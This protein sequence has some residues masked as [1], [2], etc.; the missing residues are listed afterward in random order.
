M[1]TQSSPLPTGIKPPAFS[2]Q[3]SLRTLVLFCH[4][5]YPELSKAFLTIGMG[6]KFNPATDIPSLDGKVILVTGGMYL[7]HPLLPLLPSHPLT[8]SHRQ[9]WPRQTNHPQPRRAQPLPHLPRRP[10]RR[11]GR[12]SDKRYPRRRPAMLRNHPPPAGPHL[13]LVHRRGGRDIHTLRVTTRHP[14]Q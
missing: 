5:I 10:H 12:N 4:T 11:E 8:R 9:C 6:V 3:E 2:T 7:L 13:V 1:A 14:H